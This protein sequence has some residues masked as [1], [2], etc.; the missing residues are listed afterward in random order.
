MY[1]LICIDTSVKCDYILLYIPGI[2]HYLLSLANR[3]LTANTRQQYSSRERSLWAPS[4]QLQ[5]AWMSINRVRCENTEQKH[6]AFTHIRNNAE[7]RPKRSEWRILLYRDR[8][9]RAVNWHCSRLIWSLHR[10]ANQVTASTGQ[11]NNNRPVG[12]GPLD[13]DWRVQK[14]L[15]W[16]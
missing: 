14:I 1:Y 16:C 9:V 12:I 11:R 8:R 15:K 3:K 5:T 2:M 6:P 7:Y 13:T 4:D 10:P